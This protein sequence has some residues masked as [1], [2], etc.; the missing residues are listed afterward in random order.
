MAPLGSYVRKN[1]S[2]ASRLQ[3]ETQP[4]QIENI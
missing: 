3:S 4:I 1:I 2:D